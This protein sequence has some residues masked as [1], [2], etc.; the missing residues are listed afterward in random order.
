MKKLL[1]AIISIML[2]IC[3]SFQSVIV[4]SAEGTEKYLSELRIVYADTYEEAKS[5][6][7]SYKAYEGYEVLK[8]NL[9]SNT[10]KDGVWLAYKTSTDIEDAITDLSVIQ[11]GGGYKLGNYKQMIAESK[12]EYEAMGKIYEDAISYFAEAYYEDHFLAVLAYRQLNFYTGADN[13]PGYNLGDLFID[14]YL[15]YT[16]LAKIFMRGNIHVLENI[17]TLLTMGV[18]Y[19]DDGKTYLEKVGEAAAEVKENP[20]AFSRDKDDYDVLAALIAPNIVSFGE[21]FVELAPY[22]E[23]FDF[24]DDEVTEEEL[25]YVEYKAIADMMRKIDYLDGKKLYDFCLNYK[26]DENDYSSLYPLAAALNDGQVAMTKCL[27]Y[28]HVVRYSMG[29]YPEETMSNDVS[30]LEEKYGVNPFNIYT[31]V[32]LSIYEGSFAL[33]SNAYREDAV[34]EGYGL[35]DSLFGNGAWVG[36]SLQLAALPASAG[37]FAWAIVRTK[38]TM[39]M[40]QTALDAANQS[41]AS[42]LESCQYQVLEQ[43]STFA[44]TQVPGYHIGGAFSSNGGYTYDQIINSLIEKAFPNDAIILNNMNTMTFAD[45]VA[46]LQIQVDLKSSLL[47]PTDVNMINLA[48]NKMKYIETNV[49][50]ETQ[51]ASVQAATVSLGSKLFTGFLYIAGG[52]LLAYS[53]YGLISTVYNHYNPEYEDVPVAMVDLI[54]TEYGDRYIKYDA[55]LE[56]ETRDDEKYI[57]GD[58][59]AYSAQR[60]VALY[61]TKS[62]EAGKPLLAQ[63]AYSTYNNKAE[64]KYLPVKRFGEVVCYNLNSY[65]FRSSSDSIYLSVLQ[66]DKQ[67]SAVADVPEVVGSIF[68][69]GWVFLAGSLGILIGVGITLGVQMIERRKKNNPNNNVNITI[70]DSK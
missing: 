18:A 49:V 67:K 4:V 10:G 33:T 3:L 26:I 15:D 63:F 43:Q 31:G 37:L 16:E 59:N 28:N 1:C 55:V 50:A 51:E 11:M 24:E 22:E 47:S 35:S 39:A 60:W 69:E 53:A 25:K 34:T 65:N 45:K 12:K 41:Y 9:N 48:G 7:Q 52:L 40:S 54:E 30:K 20:D 23:K 27:Q 64:T 38:H 5:I 56:A 44:A 70:G 17:R 21:M 6:I 14:E 61:Y 8:Y 66:S 36:T 42:V 62:Y 2:V 29:D 57:P 46:E 13:Y 68:S 58:L 19:N 32:D